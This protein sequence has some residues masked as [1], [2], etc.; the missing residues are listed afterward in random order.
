MEEKNNLAEMLQ[1]EEEKLEKLEKKR[2]EIDSKIK[3]AKTNI[4]KY[5]MLL[6]NYR[7]NKLSNALD[8]AGVDMSELLDAI[9]K[10]DLS[11]IQKKI[12]DAE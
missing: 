5:K 6:N 2:I 4:G 7:F 3:T 10:G 12:V 9:Q 11:A 8:N 1:A